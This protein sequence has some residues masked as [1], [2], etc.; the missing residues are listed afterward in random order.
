MA[1]GA[2][3]FLFLILLAAGGCADRYEDAV[4]LEEQGRFLKAAAKYKAFALENPKAADAPKA[5]LAAANLYA[6]KLG[7]CHESKPLLERL[8]RDYPSFNMPE[9]V[10]RRIFVCP[11]YFPAG[12]G[13]KWTYGD[14]QTL[15]KNARQEV[16]VVDHT[17]RGAVISSAFY[18]G[19]SL[20]SR[21]KKAYRFSSMNFME[22]QDR[23]ETLILNY[24]LETGKA[25]TSSGPEGRLE[26]RVEATGQK[27]KVKAGEFAGCVKIRRRSPGMPSWILEYYAPWT[28]KVLTSVAGKG[29]ENRVTELLSYEEKK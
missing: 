7:V 8:A 13:L 1:K 18:A 15:G 6:L 16:A 25:W 12:P 28:G 3:S 23:G 5:L 11:D 21:Q 24:P 17:S 9:D 20:V 10:F 27:V 22:R 26:F 19:R 4:V 29:F 2:S 14:S